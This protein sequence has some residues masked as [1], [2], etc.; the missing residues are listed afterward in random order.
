[1]LSKTLPGSAG[2]IPSRPVDSVFFVCME[3]VRTLNKS[4]KWSFGSGCTC[5]VSTPK[6]KRKK[7]EYFWQFFWFFMKKWLVV[8]NRWSTIF[9]AFRRF[10]FSSKASRMLVLGKNLHA[11]NHVCSPNI[12]NFCTTDAVELRVDRNFRSCK[13]GRIHDLIKMLLN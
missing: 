7:Y 1:M 3:P 9:E 5:T 10:D 2:Q 11:L 12:Q 13:T 4:R 6:K 8:Q